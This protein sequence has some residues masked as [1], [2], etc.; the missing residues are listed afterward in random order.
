MPRSARALE[1]GRICH[2]YNRVGG[3]SMPFSEDSLPA[4]FQI[5]AWHQKSI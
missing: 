3:E 4:R 1:E 5:G 2:V